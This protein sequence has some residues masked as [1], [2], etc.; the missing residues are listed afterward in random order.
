MQ[1]NNVNKLNKNMFLVLLRTWSSKYTILLLLL[2][3]MYHSTKFKSVVFIQM[4]VFE[5]IYVPNVFQCNIV[6]YRTMSF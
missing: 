3:I 6:L 5:D 1:T 2:Y 4:L